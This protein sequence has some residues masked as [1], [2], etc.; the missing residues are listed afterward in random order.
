MRK[1]L[2]IAVG[3]SICSLIFA[4]EDD[5]FSE[6]DIA[7]PINETA[8]LEEA[9]FA[10]QEWQPLS[11]ISSDP[12][13]RVR[14]YYRKNKPE[15]EARIPEPKDGERISWGLGTRIP[16]VKIEA[17]EYS[18]VRVEDISKGYH[19]RLVGKVRSNGKH[20]R[21]LEASNEIW[22]GDFI[23]K[24]NFKP[25]PVPSIDSNPVAM[26]SSSKLLG[27]VF[28]IIEPGQDGE[29]FYS[30]TRQLIGANFKDYQDGN[31]VSIGA[32]MSIR[33]K[34]E[35]IANA[36]VVD[37]DRDLATLYLYETIREVRAEDKIFTK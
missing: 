20:L 32:L 9:T 3:A 16:N 10:S 29:V 28:A 21:V 2:L 27:E 25:V 1:I 12:D 18:V 23:V 33:R 5:L 4:Q 35:L 19:V 34:G 36:V 26:K 22:T 30:G 13:F 6:L 17:G 24:E 8:P 7:Q 11:T 15:R 31:A 14:D 37:A